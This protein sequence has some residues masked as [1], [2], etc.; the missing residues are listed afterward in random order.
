[1]ANRGGQQLRRGLVVATL[2][3]LAGLLILSGLSLAASL[4]G[5]AVAAH[6]FLL[7]SPVLV[8]AALL[9]EGGAEGGKHAGIHGAGEPSGEGGGG[10]QDAARPQTIRRLKITSTTSPA[11]RYRTPERLYY[12]VCHCVA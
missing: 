5:L 7:L 12:Y 9:G 11:V 1:M 6:L 10:A 8:P 2:L 3:A 4:V